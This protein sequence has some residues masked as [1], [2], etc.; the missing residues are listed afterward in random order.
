M[1]KLILLLFIPL[2][3]FGQEYQYKIKNDVN[4]RDKPSTNSNIIRVLKKDEI[5]KVS[6][7]INNWFKLTDDMLNVGYVSKNYVNKIKIEAEPYDSDFGLIFSYLLMFIIA[8]F[9]IFRKLPT[10]GSKSRNKKV[11]N[12][13]TKVDKP[14]GL[15]DKEDLI[16]QTEVNKE[17][18]DFSLLACENNS[19]SE[20]GDFDESKD[21]YT[22]NN[23]AYN[24]SA[25]EFLDWKKEFN[26]FN[27]KEGKI[28]GTKH[29]PYKYH[30]DKLYRYKETTYLNGMIILTKEYIIGGG[31][32]NQVTSYHNGK[33]VQIDDYSTAWPSG[34]VETGEESIKRTRKYEN[35]EKV[36]DI[37]YDKNGKIVNEKNEI[38]SEPATFWEVTETDVFLYKEGELVAE[39]IAYDIYIHQWY[40]EVDDYQRES[41]H[42]EI[43]VVDGKQVDAEDYDEV[44]WES[45][46]EIETDIDNYNDAEKLL[47]EIS[48]VEEELIEP[49]FEL[50]E[51]MINQIKNEIIPELKY[52]GI[53]SRDEYIK[54]NEDFYDNVDL[55]QRVTHIFPVDEILKINKNEFTSEF[56]YLQERTKRWDEKFSIDEEQLIINLGM[57]YL[58]STEW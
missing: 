24:G 55:F 46:T 9:W 16:N 26:Y 13:Q 17:A 45:E 21:V 7:S 38:S 27:F 51:E 29:T 58:E 23:K 22:L 53:N 44:V 6:D 41:D 56:E 18:I 36:S 10:F 4:F 52:D 31:P 11:L 19:E 47:Y 2:V 5:V 3:S 34:N 48:G 32:L 12:N 54:A 35:G 25:K 57:D 40:E 33:V 42:G 1:K 15:K 30:D 43:I 49:D 20:N 28:S 50:T 8:Y 39:G 37:E 14:S